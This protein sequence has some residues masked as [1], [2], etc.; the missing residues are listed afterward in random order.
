MKLC[1]HPF[2]L[3]RTHITAALLAASLVMAPVAAFAVA[4]VVPVATAAHEDHAEA[5]IKDLHAKLMITQAQEAQWGPVAQVMR[6]NA[7]VMDKLT[8]ARRDRAKDTNAVD[9]LK[10]YG[11]IADA[12]AEGLKKLTPV[13]GAL[14]ASMSDPQKLQADTLF[15]HG[16]KKRN[17]KRAHKRAPKAAAT[18]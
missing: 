15:R 14:Y 5:R 3:A 8:Q 7:K 6:D 13:F 10:S 1:S 16:E 11:E 17:G 12:H 2:D 18:Q 4:P 9:D